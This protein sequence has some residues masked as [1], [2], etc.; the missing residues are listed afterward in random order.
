MENR[1]KRAS[2]LPVYIHGPMR[3]AAIQSQSFLVASAIPP[4]TSEELE[5]QY[6]VWDKGLGREREGGMTR[7]GARSFKKPGASSHFREQVRTRLC[8][9]NSWLHPVYSLQQ[10]QA[11]DHPETL[12][13]KVTRNRTRPPPS[14]RLPR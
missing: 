1:G 11:R 4:S 14:V 13:T 12:L 8:I 2:T 6:R 3:Q 9:D 7:R 5:Q 10:T